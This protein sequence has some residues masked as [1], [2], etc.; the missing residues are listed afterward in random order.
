MCTKVTCDWVSVRN[1]V[2]VW[3]R[4]RVRVTCVLVTHGYNRPAGTS[5]YLGGGLRV[6]VRVE[7]QG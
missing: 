5:L 2:R 4:V 6:R 1:R 3:V 7:G